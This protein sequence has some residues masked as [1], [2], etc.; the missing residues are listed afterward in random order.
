MIEH[1]VVD[2]VQYKWGHW[3]RHWPRHDLDGA[4]E[5]LQGGD[6]HEGQQRRQEHCPN[7][8]QAR[9]VE[10]TLPLDLNILDETSY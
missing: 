7:K 8:L 6:H 2:A 1:I 3:V 10:S 9:D 5:G 4:E